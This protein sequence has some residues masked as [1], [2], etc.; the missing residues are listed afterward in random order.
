MLGAIA[1]DII[2]SVHE[3]K[4]RPTKTKDFG[5]LFV[6]N[7][8]PEKTMGGIK[9]VSI[10]GHGHRGATSSHFTDDTVCSIAVARWLLDRSQTVDYHMRK[11]CSTYPRC[12]YGG[13]FSKWVVNASQGP[14]N[15]WG[16][17]APMRV[18]PVGWAS[19]SLQ[20]AYD[21]AKESADITHSHPQAVKGA[22]AVAG[23]IYL[24][25]T[26]TDKASAIEKVIKDLDSDGYYAEV[27]ESTLD[28]IRPGYSFR[29]SSQDTVPQAIRCLVEGN[30]YEDVVRN[31]ISLGG[32][33]DTIAAIAGS[34]A[35][36][37]YGI[38]MEIAK[39]ALVRLDD[40]LRKTVVE[41]ESRFMQ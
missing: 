41:F 37:V 9:M 36:T 4:S 3:F 27:L 13:M 30:S 33:A 22:Q 8:K 11:T 7:I 34:M 5:D 31:A 23:I 14:Y 28:E 10:A 39:E 26:G 29:V 1:G 38:P 32:D 40:D 20:E 2:G 17:G 24:T 16:N 15:S 35:E 25:R 21:L 6:D 18:S 12:G 19:S